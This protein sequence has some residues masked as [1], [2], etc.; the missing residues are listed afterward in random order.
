V[1]LRA[2]QIIT[3]D[4][5]KDLKDLIEPANEGILKK[6]LTSQVLRMGWQKKLGENEQ[7]FGYP[8]LL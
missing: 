8:A 2:G 5:R 3:V 6:A 7:L 1:D 4:W